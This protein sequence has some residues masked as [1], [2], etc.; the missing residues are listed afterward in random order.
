VNKPIVRPGNLPLIDLAKG[1]AIILIIWDHLVEQFFGGAYFF[2]PEVHWPPISEQIAQV[3]APVGAGALGIVGALIRDIGWLGDEGVGLFLVLS[4]FGLGWGIS[5]AGSFR[6]WQFLER[7]LGRIY[8]MWLTAHAVIGL[9]LL[10]LGR[11]SL[12]VLLLSAIGVR[13]LPQTYFA[14]VPAWWYVGL[15]LQL[16]LTVPI[17]VWACRRLGP[18]GMI[19]GSVGIGLAVRAVGW[20]FAGSYIDEWSR[21]T[22]FLTRLPEFAFGFGLAV[23]STDSARF[24]N[25][26]RTPSVFIMAVMAFVF[27]NA[28][29]MA[30]IGMIFAPLLCSVGS[31]LVVC[32]VLSKVR[33]P[34]MEWIGKHSYSLYLSHQFTI[35]LFV[36]NI[37]SVSQ[38]VMAVVLA[39]VTGVFLALVLELLTSLLQRLFAGTGAVLRPTS[40]R[41]RKVIQNSVPFRSVDCSPDIVVSATDGSKSD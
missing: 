2:N 36:R 27:G 8:P 13:F 1:M 9:P 12:I 6:L 19:V 18:I 31:F 41:N 39:V 35:L 3:L 28:L 25:F 37:H 30:W 26:V 21:G 33:L 15:L 22:I 7:R 16:Y 24:I 29:S 23:W 10:I 14:I 17:L 4:G 38:G 32:A 11:V 34:A 40:Y 5:R 20:H